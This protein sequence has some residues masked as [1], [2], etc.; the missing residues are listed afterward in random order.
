MERYICT[1]STCT[2]DLEIFARKNSRLLNVCIGLFS[3]PQ[4]T[5]SAASFLLFN[6]G[7]YSCFKF[8]LS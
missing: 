8:S 7:K 2:V 6:V 4:N 3:S 1:C 5:G